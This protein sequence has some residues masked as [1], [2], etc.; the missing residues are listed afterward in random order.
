MELGKREIDEFQFPPGRR[1][2]LVFDD[3]LPGFGL[4]VTA[5]G[6]KTFLYQYRVGPKVRRLV[7]GEYGT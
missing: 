1:D 3:G 6:T 2:V 5:A 7:L 4:R